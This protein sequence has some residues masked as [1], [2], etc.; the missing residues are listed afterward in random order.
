M[1]I[2]AGAGSQFVTN[3]IHSMHFLQ[4]WASDLPAKHLPDLKMRGGTSLEIAAGKRPNSRRIIGATA[5]FSRSIAK[6]PRYSNGPIDLV[7]VTVRWQSD[8]N[9]AGR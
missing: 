1:T 4:T 7:S 9:M 8:S 6:L 2:T 5:A 3:G